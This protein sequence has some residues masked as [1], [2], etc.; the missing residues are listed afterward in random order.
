MRDGV[1][2]GNFSFAKYG[3]SGCHES[4][5]NIPGR[6][7]IRGLPFTVV[8]WQPDHATGDEVMCLAPQ[9]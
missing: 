7:V 4:T 6:D 1:Y 5:D 2:V 3:R 8:S 9:N